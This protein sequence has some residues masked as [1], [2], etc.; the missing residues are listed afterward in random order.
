[1]NLIFCNYF[2]SLVKIKVENKTCV[3]TTLNKLRFF[4]KAIS[5]KISKKDFNY[6]I[7]L[8]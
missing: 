7:C 6:L 3:L 5:K 8:K 2:L 4:F 1:M